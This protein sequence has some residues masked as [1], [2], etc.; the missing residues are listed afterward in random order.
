MTAS[1]L[2]TREYPIIHPDA[3]VEEVIRRLKTPNSEPLPVCDGDRL[4]GMVGYRDVAARVLAGV[5]RGAPVRARDVVAPDIVY[6]L[7]TTD[8]DEAAAL[9]RDNDVRSLPVLNN[10]RRLVG[11]LAL[12]SVPND[13]P[14][15]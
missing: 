2:M 7:E 14:V 6:C 1:E 8:L 12:A 5:R 3:P 11:I 4:I 9:M 10:A 13:H 15:A